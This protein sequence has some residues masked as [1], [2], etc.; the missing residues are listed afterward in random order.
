MNVAHDE[1]DAT[2]ARAPAGRTREVILRQERYG[3]D[4][5]YLGAY[6][7]ENGD[8]RIEGQDLGPGTEPWGVDGEYEWFETVRAVHLPRLLELLG[9]RERLEGA[10]LVDYLE[11]EW[12]GRRA[13]DFLR[14]L[15]RSGIPIER[16]VW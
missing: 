2:T 4:S 3:R 16:E 14:L 13:Y 9:A 15:Y 10:E 11:R 7:D 8:L 5:R 1:A 6:I 12:S